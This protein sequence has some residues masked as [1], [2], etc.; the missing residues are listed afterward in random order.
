MKPVEI[1]LMDLGNVLFKIQPDRVRRSFMDLGITVDEVMERSFLKLCYAYEQGACSTNDFLEQCSS[2][3]GITGEPGHNSI[4][5]AFNSIFPENALI[6]FTFEICKKIKQHHLAKLVLF[7]NTNEIHIDYLSSTYPGLFELTDATIYSHTSKGMKPD[8]PMYLEAV[9]QLDALPSQ[10]LYFDDKKEN[11]D[12]ALSYG[13]N[14]HVF[15]YT[16]PGTFLNHLPK[17]WME[18]Q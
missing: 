12:A 8:A 4:R 9:N 15:D 16:K 5:R 13:F 11:I 10:I 18:I 3:M 2:L 17:E 7:S 1:L 14:A 6:P